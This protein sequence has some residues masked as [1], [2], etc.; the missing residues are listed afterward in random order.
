MIEGPARLVTIN[1][2]AA[3]AVTSASGLKVLSRLRFE[4]TEG[5]HRHG[6]RS[7]WREW[8]FRSPMLLKVQKKT[9]PS[10]RSG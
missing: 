6:A 4:R 2:E 5:A 7:A 8:R 3:G 1:R 10:L 9:G